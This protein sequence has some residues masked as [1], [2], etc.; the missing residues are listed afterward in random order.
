MKWADLTHETP[1]AE[2]DSLK[3]VQCGHMILT[4]CPLK[5]YDIQSD[6]IYL[7]KASSTVFLTR[8][9]FLS[10]DFQGSVYI[11]INSQETDNRGTSSLIWVTVM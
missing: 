4:I 11:L 1:E 10:E 2:N 9:S 5:P 7:D 6:L 3:P 8:L